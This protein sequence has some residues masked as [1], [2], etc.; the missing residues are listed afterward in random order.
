MKAIKMMVIIFIVYRSGSY[1]TAILENYVFYQFTF[2]SCL[3][4]FHL[5]N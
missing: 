1:L 4:A 5:E 2:L 3:A